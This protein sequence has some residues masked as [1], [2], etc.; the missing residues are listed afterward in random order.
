MYNVLTIISAK[1][2][3]ENRLF[4]E[5]EDTWNCHSW[6]FHLKILCEILSRLPPS[7][8]MI[9]ILLYRAIAKSFYNLRRFFLD[10]HRDSKRTPFISYPEF[11]G[12][13]QQKIVADILLNID[14]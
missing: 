3:P 10:F 14:K 9:H 2:Y 11:F 1:N 7:F 12:E 8:L 6:N 4:E 5:T 13:L